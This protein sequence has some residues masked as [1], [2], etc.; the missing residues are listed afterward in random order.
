MEHKMKGNTSKRVTNEG[1]SAAGI[2][3]PLLNKWLT[4]QIINNLTDETAQAV[5]D[6]IK[7]AVRREKPAVNGI[8]YGEFHDTGQLVS[9]NRDRLRD[10]LLNWEGVKDVSEKQPEQ[11]GDK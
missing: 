4:A 11:Q 8:Y 6:L 7:A 1:K 3:H 9:F 5:A 10:A 2:D